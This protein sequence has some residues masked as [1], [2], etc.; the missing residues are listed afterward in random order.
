MQE[1]DEDTAHAPNQKTC[2]I[3][4]LDSVK[5]F[6][7]EYLRTK[8]YYELLLSY[9]DW[10]KMRG[11]TRAYIW[12]CPPQTTEQDYILYC[13]PK[14]QKTPNNDRLR[15]WYRM[16]VIEGHRRRL[17]ASCQTLYDA[18]MKTDENCCK[19]PFFLGD[20]W[21]Q[22][23]EI[24]VKDLMKANKKST[25]SSAGA[26]GNG[27]GKANATSLSTATT[28][29]SSTGKSSRRATRSSDAPLVGSTSSS[30]RDPLMKKLAATV[31]DSKDNF[32]V[33]DFYERCSEC[34]DFIVH[35]EQ[36]SCKECNDLHEQGWIEHTFKRG[37]AKLAAELEAKTKEKEEAI[38]KA[39]AYLNDLHY[40]TSK[41]T[42]SKR[43]D[44]AEGAPNGNGAKKGSKDGENG[45]QSSS[46]GSSA[47]VTPRSAAQTPGGSTSKRSRERE[48]DKPPKHPKFH[49]CGKCYTAH[50]QL[51]TEQQHPAGKPHVH[52]LRMTFVKSRLGVKDTRD[53]DEQLSSPYFNDREELLLH[54][55]QK[56]YQFDQIRRAKHSTMMF[57]HHIFNPPS[58]RLCDECKVTLEGAWYGCKQCPEFD[59][60]EQCFRT[61]GSSH[62]PGHTLVRR[63]PSPNAFISL[64]SKQRRR[65]QY[66]KQSELLVHV[67]SCRLP[68][69]P[70][71]GSQCLSMRHLWFEHMKNCRQHKQRSCARCKFVND[72]FIFHRKHC[73][74]NNC[75]VPQCRMENR[76]NA[77]ATA[78]LATQAQQSQ[79]DDSGAR[80]QAA[81]QSAAQAEA[82]AAHGAASAAGG[83]VTGTVRRTDGD[84]NGAM[85]NKE[86]TGLGAAD[87]PAVKLQRLSKPVRTCRVLICAVHDIESIYLCPALGF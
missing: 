11:F 34:K 38:A 43:K 41:A 29:S 82:D 30:A 51:S 33:L 57:L 81:R 70:K 28:P 25:S 44:A 61:Q 65:R 64:A 46:N 40:G 8:L 17:V 14:T 31:H 24:I 13:H 2:Y 60:C 84:N 45:E 47:A 7:P 16:M 69:C 6:R 76:A 15:T 53:I 23:A 56:S 79:R 18:H 37:S 27:G 73:R 50:Q 68:R 77:A 58:N 86:N 10:V 48:K 80:A 35:G 12:S 49:L 78:Q 32:L 5:Y 42:S 3:A 54:C 22:I 39:K 67:M 55:Q 19:L 21:P 52:E 36:W 20:Y 62:E 59:L 87:D 1:Y 63:Q 74:N 26:L 4:Y 85:K 75:P 83:H 66:K 72:V 71:F 9:F